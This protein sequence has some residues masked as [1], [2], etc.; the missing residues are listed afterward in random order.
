MWDERINSFYVQDN[1]PDGGLD[2]ELARVEGGFGLTP[3]Q[4]IVTPDTLRSFARDRYRDVPLLL[5]DLFTAA[6]PEEE[7]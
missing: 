3:Q 1:F 4:H 7:S 6:R 2:A 5:E